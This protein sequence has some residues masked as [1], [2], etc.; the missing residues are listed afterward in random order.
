MLCSY[1]EKMSIKEK[2]NETRA[3]SGKYFHG[4][5]QYF[6]EILENF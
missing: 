6:K 2:V 5:G 3:S 1:E 4:S